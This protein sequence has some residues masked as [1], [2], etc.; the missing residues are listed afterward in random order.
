M[1]HSPVSWSMYVTESLVWAAHS[2]SEMMVS[3]TSSKVIWLVA[4]QEAVE[5]HPGQKGN[6]RFYDALL[7]IDSPV[8]ASVVSISRGQTGRGVDVRV[9][10]FGKLQQGNVVVVLNSR[11]VILVD[12][13]VKC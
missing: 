5:P 1:T 3:S 2:E 13:W 8:L 12:N 6:V 4:G 7:T 10:L 9:D 11:L